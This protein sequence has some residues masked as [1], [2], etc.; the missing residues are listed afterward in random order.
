MTFIC[1][2]TASIKDTDDKYSH[3]AISETAVLLYLLFISA[4]VIAVASLGP[5]SGSEISGFAGS[6]WVQP[7]PHSLTK[8]A[9]FEQG[10][11]HHGILCCTA[12]QGA[13][14]QVKPRSCYSHVNTLTVVIVDDLTQA[15][16]F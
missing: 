4:V 5:V 12:N 16:I 13:T 7:R 10:G 2:V 8:G 11:E 6:L 15:W 14:K 1:K 9:Y 3:T